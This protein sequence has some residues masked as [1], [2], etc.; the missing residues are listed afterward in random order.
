[1]QTKIKNQKEL[2]LLE[3]FIKRDS[4]NYKWKKALN[5]K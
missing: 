3:H 1:M 5:F 2:K 4:E